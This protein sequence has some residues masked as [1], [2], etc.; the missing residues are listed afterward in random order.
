MASPAPKPPAGNHND[1]ALDILR[2]LEPALARVTTDLGEIKGE[3]KQLDDRLRR[4][5]IDVAEIRGQ[6]KSMPTLR[7][8]AALI[9]ALFGS[10]FVLIRFASGH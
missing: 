5:E 4:V 10:A 2:R 9:F 3:V 7:T 1:E 6:I 8:L